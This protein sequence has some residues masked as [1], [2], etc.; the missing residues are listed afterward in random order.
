MYSWLYLVDSQNPCHRLDWT[1]LFTGKISFP[2]ACLGYPLAICFGQQHF[3]KALLASFKIASLWKLFLI[4]TW[5]Y[6]ARIF[7]FFEPWTMACFKPEWFLG[8]VTSSHWG[9]SSFV[10]K[11][12]EEDIVLVQF[13]SC[14]AETSSV[15]GN[16]FPKCIPLYPVQE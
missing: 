13:R 10:G 12:R 4:K 6:F 2:I 15:K 8:A 3:M 9:N 5:L 7:W 16:N 11:W 14:F 1:R